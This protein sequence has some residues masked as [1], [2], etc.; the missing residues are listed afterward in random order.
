MYLNNGIVGLTH[1]FSVMALTRCALRR[2]SA[3]EGICLKASSRVFFPSL[4][5]IISGSNSY[6]GCVTAHMMLCEGTFG[7]QKLCRCN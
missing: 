4:N 1:D 2:T 6:L 7:S 3:F 5:R